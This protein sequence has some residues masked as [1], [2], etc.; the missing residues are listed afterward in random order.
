MAHLVDPNL[1]TTK[2]HSPTSVL[3][4][5]SNR[6]PRQIQHTWGGFPYQKTRLD[7]HPR[8]LTVNPKNLVLGKCFSFS[9]GG[10]FS[11]HISLPSGP[12][13]QV[14]SH[15]GPGKVQ[16]TSD[17]RS[18]L[19]FSLRGSTMVWSPYTQPV[20][21]LLLKEILHHFISTMTI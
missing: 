15:R 2:E 3:E 8:K 16:N 6:S 12:V 20:V 4:F 7:G 18:A 11:C 19:E 10:I 5:D 17:V 13:V 9:K 21:V 14:V 1:S